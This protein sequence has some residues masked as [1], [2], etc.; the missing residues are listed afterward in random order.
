MKAGSAA[1]RSDQINRYRK[2]LSADVAFELLSN[3]FDSGFDLIEFVVE[4][5]GGHEGVKV[6]FEVVSVLGGRDFT[7]EA[8]SAILMLA[9]SSG[10]GHGCIRT[11]C[12]SGTS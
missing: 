8:V 11:I 4:G 1:T 6:A 5:V 10:G 3:F 7:F 2:R 9:I 12:S